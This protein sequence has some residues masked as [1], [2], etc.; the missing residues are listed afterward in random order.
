MKC[1]ECVY[2]NYGRCC[3]EPLGAWDWAPCELEDFEC[4]VVGP[5]D[6]D[7]EEFEDDN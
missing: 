7:W 3:Y 5:D 6:E 2:W 1:G 4:S